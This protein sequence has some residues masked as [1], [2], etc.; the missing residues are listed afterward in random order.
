MRATGYTVLARV[1]RRANE[2]D[3]VRPAEGVQR[4]PQQVT[5]V[6]FVRHPGN[7]DAHLHP[8]AGRHHAALLATDRRDERLRLGQ[9]PCDLTLIMREVIRLL[10]HEQQS[11][12]LLLVGVGQAR[13]T[14][15]DDVPQ[16][17]LEL[18]RVKV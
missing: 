3:L 8:V 1:Q 11:A 14:R 6:K 10:Q 9:A 5:K 13:P 7:I 16:N 2:H 15:R 18:R 17:G 4:R 12:E